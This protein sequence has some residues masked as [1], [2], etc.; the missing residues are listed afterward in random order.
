MTELRYTPYYHREAWIICIP[1]AMM[2]VIPVLIVLWINHGGGLDKALGLTIM[3]LGLAG[4]PCLGVLS[5]GLSR[6]VWSS[7]RLAMVCGLYAL[8]IEVLAI[9][10]FTVY[11]WSESIM[12]AGIAGVVLGGIW[13][14]NRCFPAQP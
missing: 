5:G 7:R 2:V 6:E 4:L 12:V 13:L 8:A 14:S 11:L 10:L 3:A 1:Y 9:M